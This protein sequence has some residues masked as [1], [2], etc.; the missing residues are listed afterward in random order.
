ML[1]ANRCGLMLRCCQEAWSSGW[2]CGGGGRSPGYYFWLI[3]WLPGWPWAAHLTSPCLSLPLQELRR[4][5]IFKILLWRGILRAKLE[6]ASSV[7]RIFAVMADLF[8]SQLHS[9]L[10]KGREY[11]YALSQR[12][13]SECSEW[14]WAQESIFQNW[15]RPPLPQL[16]DS[17][18]FAATVV[19]A[20]FSSLCPYH[21]LF[22]A[23][24][25]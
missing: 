1:L 16:T 2:G 18:L 14:S 10:W 15:P 4:A 17:R 23:A 20:P 3:C 22:A 5:K 7:N 13:Q 12:T 8:F 9:W 11:S 19:H 6:N 25:V 21:L 24:V